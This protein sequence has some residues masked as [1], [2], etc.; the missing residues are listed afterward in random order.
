[1]NAC[2]SPQESDPPQHNRQRQQPTPHDNVG[3]PHLR[4]P[5]PNEESCHREQGRERKAQA[6]RIDQPL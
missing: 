1:M 3:Q 5:Q 6:D 2:L 4:K